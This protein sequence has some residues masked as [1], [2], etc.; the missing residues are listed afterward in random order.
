MPARLRLVAPRPDED[1]IH[2]AVARRLD[3]LLMPPATWTTFPM[4]GYA[5][6]AAAA[7]RLKRLGAKRSWPDVLI[8]HLGQLH[9]IELKAHDGRLS[10]TRIVRTRGGHHRLVL[11]QEDVHRDLR[12]AGVK[13]AVCRSADQALAQVRAW[14]IPLREAAT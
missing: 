1:E 11:G 2:E 3:V 6:S 9:G 13:V 5:L 7:A 14:G 10:K 12:A 4:G 8:V